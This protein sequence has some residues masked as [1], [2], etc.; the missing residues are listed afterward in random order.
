MLQKS[1]KMKKIVTVIG[2]RPQFIKAAPVSKALE[3]CSEIEEIIVHTGQHYDSGMSKIFFKELEIP[4]PKYDLEVGSAS[5]AVQTGE[6]MKHLEE[7]LVKEKP[8]P[9]LLVL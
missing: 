2:A 3:N 5:H 8:H 1:D 7:V 6:I 4:E 9:R